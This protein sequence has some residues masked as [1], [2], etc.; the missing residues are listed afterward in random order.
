MPIPGT[1]QATKPILDFLADG[2][3]HFDEEIQ[4][5]VAKAFNLTML[6]RAEKQKNG[7]PKYKNRTAWGLVYLQDT[8]Y[9][10]GTLAYIKKIDVRNGREVYKITAAGRAAQRDDLLGELDRLD[11]EDCVDAFSSVEEG[12]G[13]RARIVARGRQKGG[14]GIEVRREG[15]LTLR[16]VF[17]RRAS[18][19]PSRLNRMPRRVNIRLRC[20]P[21][22]RSSGRSSLS[23]V[24]ACAFSIQPQE[25]TFEAIWTASPATALRRRWATLAGLANGSACASTGSIRTSMSMYWTHSGAVHSPSHEKR[26]CGRCNTYDKQ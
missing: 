14:S 16:G 18:S 3:E 26:R 23:S 19:K 8:P 25:R 6:E 17:A 1:K 9:L 22:S 10:P 20:L 12:A 21:S 2:L 11:G 24:C 5:A 4:E 7:I 13:T 15:A